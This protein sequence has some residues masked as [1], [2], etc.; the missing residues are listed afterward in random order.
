MTTF[1]N[2]ERNMKRNKLKCA[3]VF[4]NIEDLGITVSKREGDECWAL[5]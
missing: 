4:K 5:A 1:E 2:V 3:L